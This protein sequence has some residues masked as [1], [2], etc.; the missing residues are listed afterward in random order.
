MTVRFVDHEV[1][2]RE[3]PLSGVRFVVGVDPS[4]PADG[5]T[6]RTITLAAASPAV[7]CLPRELVGPDHVDAHVVAVIRGDAPDLVETDP[8][9]RCEP[10]DPSVLV[11]RSSS[12]EHVVRFLLG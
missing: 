12:S 5:A 7:G 4:A 3:H 9:R 1:H 6:L 2:V 11:G 8:D 10:V